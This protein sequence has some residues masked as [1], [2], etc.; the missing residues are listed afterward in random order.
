VLENKH[1]REQDKNQ[2]AQQGKTPAEQSK[3]KKKKK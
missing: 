1:K 3:T 2:A